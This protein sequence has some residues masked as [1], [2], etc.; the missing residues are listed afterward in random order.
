MLL[1][2]Y[3]LK[4]ASQIYDYLVLRELTFFLM[5][6]QQQQRA[7]YSNL[8]SQVADKQEGKWGKGKVKRN[9]R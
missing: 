8:L 2:L 5:Q 3:T 1:I 7:I 9:E 6:Q 4:Y